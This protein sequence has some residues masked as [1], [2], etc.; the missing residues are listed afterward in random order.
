MLEALIRQ[1]SADVLEEY[2]R[3]FHEAHEPLER[4]RSLYQGGNPRLARTASGSW[5]SAQARGG[6]SRETTVLQP[7]GTLSVA[8]TCRLTPG[9]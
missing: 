5:L 4:A 1:R 7:H 9:P 3:E 8:G 6:L 2:Y